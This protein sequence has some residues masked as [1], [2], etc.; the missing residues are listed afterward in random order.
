MTIVSRLWEGRSRGEGVKRAF[1]T[2]RVSKVNPCFKSAER[3]GVLAL[4]R[5]LE[6]RLGTFPP[7]IGH[8]AG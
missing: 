7:H 8:A 1:V 5:H 6:P 4:A 3:P 2:E